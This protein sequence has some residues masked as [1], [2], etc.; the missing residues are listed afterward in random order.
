MP[1][2]AVIENRVL[3]SHFIFSL[4]HHPFR[5]FYFMEQYATDTRVQELELQVDI[6]DDKVCDHEVYISDLIEA[7]SNDENISPAT[8]QTILIIL[9]KLFKNG[10]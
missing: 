6:I 1:E 4:T 7:L 5:L 8:K 2:R 9:D 10:K 3:F